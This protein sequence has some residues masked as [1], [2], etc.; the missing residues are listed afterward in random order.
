[1]NTQSQIEQF[2]LEDLLSG[3]RQSIDPE[4]PLYTSGI[5]DSLGTLRLITFIEERFGL[6]IGDGEVG[7]ENFRTLNRITAFV[8]QKLAAGKA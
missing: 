7:E 4:E 6:Q 3:E 5:I 1:M 8:N 2:I